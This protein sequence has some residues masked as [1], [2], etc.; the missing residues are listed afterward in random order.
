MTRKKPSRA[1]GARPAARKKRYKDHAAAFDQAVAD[2]LASYEVDP[3]ETYTQA[4][5]RAKAYMEAYRTAD[6]R[7]ADALKAMERGFARKAGLQKKPASPIRML[8]DRIET[9]FPKAIQQFSRGG[10]LT[11]ARLDEMLKAVTGKL[12][13]TPER[14]RVRKQLERQFRDGR[15]AA[16]LRRTTTSMRPV[17]KRID[18]RNGVLV[19]PPKFDIYEIFPGLRRI[20]ISK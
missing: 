20:K 18:V 7:I 12:V 5:A 3:K 11:G 17:A 4:V 10:P 16:E 19:H 13:T 1:K 8:C 15:T 14:D 9:A 6:A 2:S